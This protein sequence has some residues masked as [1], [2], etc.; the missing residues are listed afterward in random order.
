[1]KMRLNMDVAAGGI[2]VLLIV[3]IGLVILLGAQA[4]IRVTT[5][6]PKD[7]VITP[8]QTIKL[9]FSEPI[10]FEP[11]SSAIWLDPIWDGYLEYVD[12]RTIQYVPVKP[13]ELNTVYKLTITPEVLTTSG[14]ALKKIHSWEFKVRD[15]LVAY[16]VSS[17]KESSIWVVDLMGNPPHRLTDENVKINSFDI[18]QNGEFIVFTTTRVN[19]EGGIDLWRV[20][21]DGTDAEILLDCGFDLCTTPAISPNGLRIAYSR[22]AAG[23]TPDLPYGSPRIW[24]LDLESGQNSPVYENQ[25]TLGYNPSWSPDSNKLASFDGLA[26]QIRVLDLKENKQYVFPSN[27]GGPITWSPDSTKILF[28]NVVQT[29]DGLR[30]QVYIA[31]LLLNKSQPLLGEND[32]LDHA[33]YSLAWSSVEE[34]AVLGF[35]I[36]EDQPMQILWLFDPVLLEGIVIANQEEYSYNSP[37]W[38][39]WGNSLIFQ[40]FKL[41]GAFNPEIGLWRQGFNE[42]VIL[43]P[44]LMPHWLP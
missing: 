7:G 34:R 29:E 9:T 31:D 22:E 43:T 30:T 13:F 19:S 25:E 26:D 11:A 5:D 20:N 1:M 41:S 36:S 35:R 24:V 18:A 39:P 28:T 16:L 23:P 32:D 3:L 38:D 44:G 6:L 42:P 8:Y 4:G 12:S 15:P 21:R 27:T 14:H 2:L 33:Y 37:Q 40:R 17:E 10:L